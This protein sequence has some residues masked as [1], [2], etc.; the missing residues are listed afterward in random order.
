MVQY[1]SESYYQDPCCLV[2]LRG[3]KSAK[4]AHIGQI[5]PFCPSSNMPNNMDLGKM[6]YKG[7]EAYYG[8]DKNRFEKKIGVKMARKCRFFEYFEISY[9]FPVNFLYKI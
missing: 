7:I 6:L 5:C 3:V 8:H 9:T 1:H 2:F 4:N